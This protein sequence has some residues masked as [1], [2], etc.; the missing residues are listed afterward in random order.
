MLQ[1][2]YGDR[3]ACL[4]F[5]Q[6]RNIRDTKKCVYTYWVFAYSVTQLCPTLCHPMDCN[7]PGFSVHGI[8]PARR[9]S[10][11]LLPFSGDFSDPGIETVSPVSPV[12]K[13]VSLPPSC[14]GSSH[15]LCAYIHVCIYLYVYLKMHT[16]VCINTHIHISCLRLVA[17]WHNATFPGL[18]FVWIKV[19][20]FCTKHSNIVYFWQNASLSIQ[21][22]CSASKSNL[23]LA[24]WMDDLILKWL[25]HLKGH[26]YFFFSMSKVKLD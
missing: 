24:E 15:A 2:K 17:T 5:C 10:E 3:K 9:W 19:K 22:Y 23:A 7:P 1:Y 12:L 6:T 18:F 16:Y 14:G 26:V 4:F 13:A 8:I 20:G 11:L 21:G 25:A